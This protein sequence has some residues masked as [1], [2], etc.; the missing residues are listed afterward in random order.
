MNTDWLE[1]LKQNPPNDWGEFFESLDE[2]LE[3]IKTALSKEIV[4][5]KCPNEPDN[6]TYFAPFYLTPISSIKLV[7]VTNEPLL[8]TIYGTCDTKSQ[9]LGFSLR[10]DDLITPA[11]TNIY[12][13]ICRTIPEFTDFPTH[14]DIS[15]WAKRGIFF[16]TLS[17]SI[18]PM[19]YKKEK[20]QRSHSKVWAVVIRKFCELVMSKNKECVWITFGRDAASIRN[21]LTSRSLI[22]EA[23][24]PSSPT[25]VGSDCFKKIP[26]TIDW[27]L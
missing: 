10:K 3:E 6:N 14:G 2:D 5:Y 27:S 20:V 4:K 8:G 23:P 1:Q 12:S 18:N 9:G 16:L 19:R 24:H 21:Y 11:I 7:F 15:Q 22:I 26:F 17:L 25:F 13:E